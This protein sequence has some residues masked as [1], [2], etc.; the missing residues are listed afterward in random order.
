MIKN[1]Q[2]YESVA[3]ICWKTDEIFQSFFLR[4][5]N[6]W[7]NVATY[8]KKMKDQKKIAIVSR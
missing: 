8:K 3:F 6:L 1:K 2:I 7:I 4:N 5:K